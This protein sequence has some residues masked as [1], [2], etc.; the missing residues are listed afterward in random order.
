MALHHRHVI[1]N[2]VAELLQGRTNAG[3]SVFQT[4]YKEWRPGELPALAVYALEETVDPES[5]RSAPRELKRTLQLAIQGVVALSADVDAAL[6]E[7]ARQVERV[8]HA[9]PWLSDSKGEA[10][11]SD[12]VLAATHLGV[13]EEGDLPVGLVRLTYT[14]TYYTP[15]P[16]AEDLP[17]LADFT[18]AHVETNLRGAQ[19][20]AD[21][22][23]DD[24][25]VPQ[26]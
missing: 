10:R 5:A 1:R 20:A 3:H 19:A 11:V 21:R 18:K 4:R 9:D 22:A 13:D 8:M 24:V 6:D 15:A 23:Q 25:A 7:L 2:A 12:S 16:A 14:V 17:P 26:S